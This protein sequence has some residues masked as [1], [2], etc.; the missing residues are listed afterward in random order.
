MRVEAG[1]NVA[2]RQGSAVSHAVSH[3]SGVRNET[4]NTAILA[5]LIIAALYLGRVVLLPFAAAMIVAFILSPIV[6]TLRKAYVPK[7]AAVAIVVLAT[8]G[9]LFALGAV[10]T[11][12]TRDLVSEIP[13]YEVTLREKIRDLRGVAKSSPDLERATKTLKDLQHELEAPAPESDT[14]QSRQGEAGGSEASPAGVEKSAKTEQR[15]TPPAANKPIENQ[16]EKTA[17]TTAPDKPIPVEIH[18]PEPTPI[19][20]VITWATPI[21]EPVAMLAI[22]IVLVLFILMQK[23]ELRDRFIRLSGASDMRRT[24][25]AMTDTGQRLSRFLL[26]LTALNVAFGT[27]VSIALWVLGIPAPVLWGIIAGL[28][29]FVPLLGIF[30][31]ITPPVL[32]AAAVDP[33]WNTLLMTFGV[34]ALSEAAMGQLVEPL[35]QGRSAGLTPLAILVSAAFWALLWGPVGLLLAV[36]MTLCLV[37]LGQHVE[38]LKFLHVLLGDEPAF[39]PGER[40]YQRTLAGDA[41]EIT[42]MAE[43]Q[44]RTEPLSVYYRDVALEGLRLAQVDADRG[45]IQGEHMQTISETVETMVDNLWETKDRLS[46]PESE[47]DEAETDN[48]RENGNIR[49]AGSSVDNDEDDEALDMGTADLPVL[50]ADELREGWQGENAV[51]CVPAKSPI[52]EAAAH[53]LAHL[54]F[55]HGVDADVA[56]RARILSRDNAQIVAGTRLICICSLSEHLAQTRYFAR[57]LARRYP[58]ARI[59]ALVMGSDIDT[60]EAFSQSESNVIEFVSNDLHAAL[61][62]I[63]ANAAIQEIADKIVVTTS[64]DPVCAIRPVEAA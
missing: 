10:L 64:D 3:L 58:E 46:V 21:M 57:R 52:D 40:F 30:I 12:Q 23:E 33:G 13:R 28:M 9:G 36:P 6:K 19:E 2:G 44:I 59:V 49:D 37:I 15:T 27:F 4:A 51:L 50:R 47:E 24:T 62:E 53:V 31:A 42:E 61:S 41:N 38:G 48:G 45:L 56:D 26:T 18:T 54:I 1:N 43:A 63:V 25:A 7:I 55:R 34:I 17:E 32:L 20:N 22:V 60:C 14:A 29:R 35:V 11:S 39:S 5:A 16:L 8:F